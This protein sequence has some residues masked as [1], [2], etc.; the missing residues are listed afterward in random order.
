MRK[1]YN[2]LHV[3]SLLFLTFSLSSCQMIM[4]S[5]YGIK[6]PK[7]LSKE[8]ILKKSHKIV[9][10]A[11][12]QY[13]I[14]A[15]FFQFNAL[16]NKDDL[17]IE[18]YNLEHGFKQPIQIVTFDNLGQLIHLA[19]NCEAGGIPNLKWKNLSTF[20]NNVFIKCVENSENYLEKIYPFLK[21]IG[22]RD[23][24]LEVYHNYDY[25]HFIIWSDFMARQSRLFIKHIDRTYK[26]E[27][28][29][30]VYV[31]NDNRFL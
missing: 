17:C 30:F 3:T 24:L 23:D 15:S 25:I 5:L 27:N 21:T 14:D 12:Y 8:K 2:V 22:E 10:E 18:Q 31:N 7:E 11:D 20:E 28:A 1:Y 9:K 29:L 6:N 4:Q 13:Y 26:K 16:L 19:T